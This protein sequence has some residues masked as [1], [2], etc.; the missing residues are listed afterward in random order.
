M[1]SDGLSIAAGVLLSLALSYL[2]GV[3][4][5]FADQ[6]PETRSL[7]TLGA[8]LVVGLLAFGISCAGLQAVVECSQPGAWS[9]VRAFVAAAVANQTTYS[10]TKRI[11]PAMQGMP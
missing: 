6:A 1:T 4:G 8:L 3:R 10:L 5:W 7:V 9:M 11:A 2:P